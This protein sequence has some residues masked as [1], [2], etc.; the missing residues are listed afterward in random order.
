MKENIKDASLLFLVAI[1]LWVFSLFMEHPIMAWL[2]KWG[3]KI[4]AGLFVVAGIISIIN[5]IADCR[6]NNKNKIEE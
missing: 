1:I 3:F 4:G 5:L 2:L 6:K